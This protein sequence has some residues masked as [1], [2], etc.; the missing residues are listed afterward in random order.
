MGL[1]EVTVWVNDPKACRFDPFLLVLHRLL[2]PEHT[3]RELV[4]PW[5]K[6]RA[7]LP[8]HKARLV[9]PLI[10]RHD[11]IDTFQLYETRL[12]F[13]GRLLCPIAGAALRA[14][15]LSRSG[16]LQGT[17][18][19]GAR[20]RD[21]APLLRQIRVWSMPTGDGR[22]ATSESPAVAVHVGSEGSPHIGLRVS[23]LGLAYTFRA[24]RGG[25]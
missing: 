7:K 12:F 20:I 13:R 24:P 19:L 8:V 23:A 21:E 6:H 5:L 4:D 10:V 22:E 2:A 11:L 3:K 16:L 17:V 15:A 9:Q 18:V 25:E 14:L 1:P